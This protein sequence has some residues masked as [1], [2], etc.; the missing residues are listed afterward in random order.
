MPISRFMLGIAEP[1]SNA[2]NDSRVIPVSP[3]AHNDVV[4]PVSRPQ[5]AKF[6]TLPVGVL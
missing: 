3:M 4:V 5:L 6:S 2:S 1:M